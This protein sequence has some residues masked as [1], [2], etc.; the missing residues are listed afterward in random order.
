MRK[1]MMFGLMAAAAAPVALNAQSQAEIRHDRQVLR[2][3][4]QDVREAR[5][6]LRDDRRDRRRHIAYASP[7]RGWRYRPVTVGYQLRPAFYGSRY[8]ISD[9][10]RYN[11]RAPGRWQRW[12]R[13]GD[14]L[15]LVNVRT[16]RVLE[17]IRNRYW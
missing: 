8:Y 4:R 13:Y 3:Q 7:Y 6:E 11:V 15:L 1:L 2:D 12:I 17:V 5:Q 9:F 16:G 14:D 10:G